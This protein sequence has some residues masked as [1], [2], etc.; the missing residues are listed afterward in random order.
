MNQYRIVVAARKGGVGKSTIACGIAS[1]FSHQSL[2]TLV[3]DLDPQSNAA[4]ILGA[5]PIAPGT[6]ELLLGQNPSPLSVSQTLAVLPGGPELGSSKIQSL[7]PEDLAEIVQTL[8]YDQGNRTH[9]LTKKK[10]K[11]QNNLTRKV[12]TR[13]QR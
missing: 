12:N 3:I 7:H 13:R 11:A 6:A 10:V 9:I 1:I 8:K 5:D 4:Y 2:R